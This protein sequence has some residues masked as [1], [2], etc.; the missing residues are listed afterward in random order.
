M[1]IFVSIVIVVGAM[2]PSIGRAGAVEDQQAIAFAHGL[3]EQRGLVLRQFSGGRVTTNVL[4]QVIPGQVNWLKGQTTCLIASRSDSVSVSQFLPWLS[5]HISQVQSAFTP[6]G[7]KGYIAI[8]TGNFEIAIQNWTSK[9]VM[10]NAFQSE[11]GKL[12]ANGVGTHLKIIKFSD[13]E[14]QCPGAIEFVSSLR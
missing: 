6:I 2:L 3:F 1:K 8:A 13:G 7:L 4:Y 11:A 9:E 5:F 14:D 10:Q 12:I